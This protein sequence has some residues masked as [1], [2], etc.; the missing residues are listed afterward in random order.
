MTTITVVLEIYFLT[1]VLKTYHL[2]L[3]K[4]F[5][6]IF[7]VPIKSPKKN[8]CF[9]F[10]VFYKN[11]TY[12]IFVLFIFLSQLLFLLLNILKPHTHLRSV[13]F[14]IIFSD[15][16]SYSIPPEHSKTSKTL[17]TCGFQRFYK[18]F[19]IGVTY[20]SALRTFYRN[21]G[22]MLV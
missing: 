2:S 18:L 10:L 7:I 1:S 8:I 17:E 20:S 22:F 21:A 6:I 5:S 14:Y 13:P 16:D 19:K 15:A 4:V 12:N 9:G 3:Y 11:S